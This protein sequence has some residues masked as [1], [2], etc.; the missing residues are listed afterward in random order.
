MRVVY[1]KPRVCLHC[2]WANTPLPN[3]HDLSLTVALFG[4]FP[5]H[6]L[7]H[8]LGLLC[9]CC[10]LTDSGYGRIHSNA[11]VEHLLQRSLR[12]SPPVSLSQTSSFP[13]NPVPQ[14]PRSDLIHLAL[15]CFGLCAA[16]RNFV[17]SRRLV[18]TWASR[19][20]ARLGSPSALRRS[21][22]CCL[23]NSNRGRSA[24]RRRWKRWWPRRPRPAPSRRSSGTTRSECCCWI[25]GVPR[26]W[27]M[28]SLS[29][30]ISLLTR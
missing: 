13:P 20:I 12:S 7:G 19:G 5:P 16:L 26:L 17:A 15:F 1:T 4:P 25:S 9:C 8:F 21:P 2:V 29:S 30:L 14:M 18:R 3:T 24:W 23:P 27:R 11:T 28:F 22:R 6:C 10:W